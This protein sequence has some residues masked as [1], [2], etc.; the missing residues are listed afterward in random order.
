MLEDIADEREVFI[1]DVDAITADIGGAEH[2][3]DG[4][5]QSGTM[6][7]LLRREIL[8]ILRTLQFNDVELA[9]AK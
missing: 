2:L 8:E 7:S 5:H 6:Q 4:I 9:A 1:V 3:P